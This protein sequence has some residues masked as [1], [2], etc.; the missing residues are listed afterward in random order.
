M[1][2]GEKDIRTSSISEKEKKQIREVLKKRW[3]SS[4]VLEEE[5]ATLRLK[6]EEL[7]K[8][9]AARYIQIQ[10]TIALKQKLGHSK[11]LGDI[12]FVRELGE[13]KKC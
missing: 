8:K 3:K 10:D 9:H 13:R 6:K 5:I 11:H 7:Q 4:E 1:E 2:K 12:D